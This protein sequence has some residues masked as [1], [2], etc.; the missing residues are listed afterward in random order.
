MNVFDEIITADPSMLSE[1]FKVAFRERLV[2]GSRGYGYWCWKPQIILQTLEK[3]RD[4]DILLYCDVGCH[5]NAEGR[6]RM[7]EYMQLAAA[8]SEG[9]LAFQAKP[10]EPPLL[11]DGRELLD[12]TDAKWT[13]GDLLDYFDVRADAAITDTPT[14]GSGIIFFRKCAASVELV[15]AWIAVYY[16]DFSLVDDSPS[17]TA[18]LAGFVEH[19]HDQSILALL[20]K[21]RGVPTLSAW[22][23]WYPKRWNVWEPDWE[24]LA[25][26]PIQARRDKDY[27][28]VG[29]AVVRVVNR[30]RYSWKKIRHP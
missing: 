27:G 10:P 3:M 24:V 29:G 23:Y 14:I 15:K 17:R 7:L 18:N 26:Y 12:L 6:W 1:E 16:A 19:R 21:K 28:L 2:S 20:C 11:H 5:L 8:A 25:K 30:V 22:E 9:V 13:K 4:G